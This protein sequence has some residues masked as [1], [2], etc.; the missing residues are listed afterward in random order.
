MTKGLISIFMILAMLI[1]ITSCDLIAGFGGD[2]DEPEIEVKDE[3]PEHVHSFVRPTCTVPE[4][5]ECGETYG[6]P[7]GHKLGEAT[8]TEASHCLRAGCDYV[9]DEYVGHLISHAC[10]EGVSSFVCQKCDEAITLTSGWYLDGTH[11]DGMIGVTNNGK[12]TTK[13][14]SHLPVITDEGT[15]Q[16]LNITD[17]NEQLQLWIPSNKSVLDDFT[18]ANNAVGFFSF[19]INADV[20]DTSS[21][22]FVDTNSTASR[23][24]EGWCITDPFF[25]LSKVYL[26]DGEM[27]V[28]VMGFDRQ[29]VG[30]AR[31]ENDDGFSGWLDVTIGIELDSDTDSIILHYYVNGKY[32]ATISKPLT[33]D[34][35]GIN[36]IYV[37]FHTAKEGMGV[38]FDDFVFGYTA[39]GKWIFD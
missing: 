2:T 36:S 14:G 27:F 8:C 9:S 24:S 34:T 17:E 38:Y 13:E 16:M 33:T 7:L 31:V 21:M 5:C 3:I 11:Y 18:S 22:K 1:A 20:A 26:L 32:G 4:T 37:N 39:N 15:Y 30:T 12:Y 23:W 19:R 25:T 28:N 10:T 6:E 29:V 35:N